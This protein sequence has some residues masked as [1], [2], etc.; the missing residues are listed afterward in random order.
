MIAAALTDISGSSDV[1]D[2][3]FITYSNESKSE[4]LGVS[5]ELIEKYGAV[6][7]EVS[8]AMVKGAIKNSNADLSVAITGIAGP[9]GGTDAKPVGLVYIATS[10]DNEIMVQKYLFGEYFEGRG[11]IR[12]EAV[13]KALEMLYKKLTD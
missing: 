12:E 8:S 13:E 4:M 1:F 5:I 9:S 2:R 11:E 3:G 7:E 10:F 6:S